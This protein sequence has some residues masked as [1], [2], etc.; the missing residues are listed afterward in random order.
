MDGFAMLVLIV[1]IAIKAPKKQEPLS[2]KNTF[3]FGKLKLRNIKFPG[4][5]EYYEKAISLPIYFDF[6]DKQL[7][8]VK[9]QLN[10]F[11]NKYY[12]QSD[13]IK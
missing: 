13:H 9:I 8:Y 11:F 6:T 5:K 12:S 7:N 10:N 1:A 4:A 2:P 3:A